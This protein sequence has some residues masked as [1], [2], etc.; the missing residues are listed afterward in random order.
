MSNSRIACCSR[1]S[2]AVSGLTWMRRLRVSSA[3][4]P[5]FERS[6]RSG[7]EHFEVW[8]DVHLPEHLH[9]FPGTRQLMFVLTMHP[10]PEWGIAGQGRTH[11]RRHQDLL[12]RVC[13]QFPDESTDVLDHVDDVGREHDICRFY[14]SLFP[15]LRHQA[16]IVDPR[17]RRDL[18][19]GSA[20]YS[21]TVLPP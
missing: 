6:G 4:L 19:G 21:V 1:A 8:I 9:Q 12:A 11:E 14:F 20:P 2:S 5:I 7:L 3:V 10:A 16:D 13:N 15:P 17:L 18:T